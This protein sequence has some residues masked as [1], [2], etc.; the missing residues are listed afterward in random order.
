MN[1]SL[2]DSTSQT[3]N[4]I[5]LYSDVT[6]DSTEIINYNIRVLGGKL[7][8]HGTV[9]NQITVIGGDVQIFPSAIIEGKIVDTQ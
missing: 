6:I 2:P 9:K 3:T 7:D 4:E 8:V 5:R 1:S